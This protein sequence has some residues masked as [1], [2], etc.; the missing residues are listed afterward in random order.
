MGMGASAQGKNI[1]EFFFNHGEE[2]IGIENNAGL[3]KEF[4]EIVGSIRGTLVHKSLKNAM[5]TL[6][7]FE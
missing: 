1:V 6:L 5:K 4:D 3:V 2:E 7:I